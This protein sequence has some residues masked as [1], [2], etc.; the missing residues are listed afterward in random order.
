MACVAER[1]CVEWQRPVVFD[2]GLVSGSVFLAG[3]RKEDRP[4]CGRV[5][6]G[7][8]DLP[9]GVMDPRRKQEDV[10]RSLS[11]A[12]LAGRTEWEREAQSMADVIAICLES[13]DDMAMLLIEFGQLAVR[14]PGKLIC[15]CPVTA[16]CRGDVELLAETEG[17]KLVCDVEELVVEVRRR[18]EELVWVLSPRCVAM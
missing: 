2:A 11:A 17:L 9:V 3:S 10:D 6:Q 7:I 5:V 14:F 12:E 15:C 13:D 16:A 18:L 4:W 8:E 1:R